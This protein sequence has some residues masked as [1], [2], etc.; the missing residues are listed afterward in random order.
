MNQRVDGSGGTMR[1]HWKG[2][3]GLVGVLGLGLS[4]LAAGGC[5]PNLP[6]APTTLAED[7]EFVAPPP[8]A[9][10]GIDEDNPAPLSILPGDVLHVQLVYYRS[11]TD[12]ERDNHPGLI[13]DETGLVQV[14]L[15]G[16]VD[17]GGMTLAEAE[18][19]LE[20]AV[21]RYDREA[22][23]NL[24]VDAFDGH[25][26]SILGAVAKPGRHP[27]TPGLRVADLIALAGGLDVRAT[28]TAVVP[29][30]DLRNA[31]LV[32]NGEVMPV[33]IAMAYSG[34][35]RHNIRVRAGDQLVVP[36]SFNNQ[37]VLLGEVE[38]PAPYSFT[39]GMRLSR[40]LSMAG[41]VTELGHRGDIRIIRGDLNAP[42]VFHA[43]L[44]DLVDGNRPDVELAAGDII[45]V[46]DE[47][48][49]AVESVLTVLNPLVQTALTGSFIFTAIEATND[50]GGGGGGE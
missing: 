29:L 3:G 11:A 34:D 22:Q 14:P 35:P 31:T 36:P 44:K 9:R 26:V 42:R 18:V 40:A 48:L 30:A 17:V 32:R 37:V 33:D 16:S 46:S 10:Q 38:A 4:L 6:R 21:Q 19:A 49:V 24:R 7:P 28:E 23:V 25:Q 13:V 8:L 12:I 39:P 41:G 5:R 15:A 20:E 27:A 2:A 45:F 50:N 1:R 43:S 47:P